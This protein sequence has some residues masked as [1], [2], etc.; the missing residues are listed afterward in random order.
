MLVHS[1]KAG[2]LLMG[3]LFI[4]LIWTV[5]PLWTCLHLGC[6]RAIALRT[7]GFLST[8]FPPR[9]ADS[10]WAA[11]SWSLQLSSGWSPSS[12]VGATITPNLPLPVFQLS[13]TNEHF[14]NSFRHTHNP[15]SW[16]QQQKL[17]TVWIAGRQKMHYNG[18][19]NCYPLQE[20]GGGSGGCINWKVQWSFVFLRIQMNAREGAGL[21]PL[22]MSE[23][24]LGVGGMQPWFLHA[25][26]WGTRPCSVLPRSMGQPDWLGQC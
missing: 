10:M 7:L 1:L 11:R 19:Q 24:G 4:F 2:K 21:E 16:R 9:W 15:L 18:Q 20:G 13:M 22:E 3:N 14:G 26:H 12:Q 6:K 5:L 23:G 25:W 17:M 8:E